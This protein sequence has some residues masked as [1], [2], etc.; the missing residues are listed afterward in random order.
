MKVIY[1]NGTVGECNPE[2]ELHIIRHSAAHIMAQA[3]K[4]LYPNAKFAYGPANEKGFYY[5]VDLGDIK[6]SDEDL[7][8]IEAEM[9]K[10]VK[11]NLPIKP[12]ILPREEAIKFMEE[13]GETYKVEHI[14]DLAEDAP[15]SFFTQ[16][17]YVDMC[18]GPHLC[19]TK[20]LKAFKI[21]SQSGAYWKNN[22][23]NTMLTR[24]NGTAFATKEELEAHL[25]ALE[26]A[27]K[28]DHNKIG[29]ELEFF[30]TVDEIGQGLPILLPKGSRVVQL[31]Q[32][33]VEDVEQKNGYLLTKTPLMAKRDLYRI[34]GHWDHYLDG[35]FILVD[36][37]DEEN[38]CL[39]L[40]PMTCPFQ[41]QVFLNKGRSYR[42]LPMRLGETS[43]LFRNEDSC[44]MH[45][46]IRVRQFTISEGHLVLRPDQLEKEFEGCLN[47]CKYFLGT[48]GL[49]DNCTFRFS[50]WDPNN[51]KKYEGTPQQWNEAQS[52]MEK[53]LNN[54]DVKYEIGID[55]AAFYGPKLDIQYKNVYGKEDTIVTIQ[56]D[57]L[58]AEKFG[59][60]YTDADG[61]K[62]LPYII[63]RTSLGCYERTL[64]YLLETYAGALPAW[65]SPEQVR[66][67]TITDRAIDKANEVYE[68]LTANGYR[69]TID[70]SANT[71]KYKVRNAQL[72][73]VPYM[74]IIGDKD[75]ENNT[76]SVRCR[77]GED[78]GT[79]TFENFAEILKDVVDN[80]KK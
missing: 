14:A 30:T 51:T 24:I 12:S 43:T 69:V 80:K 62:K 76:I 58:L 46:L 74:I 25:V 26:E 2:E 1:A 45:G 34:S 59:M 39:A 37:H 55:E 70:D 64:A 15:I 3:I 7:E 20:A 38:E 52:V 44:E 41:Y 54:L 68:K 13:R 79:T 32:R 49:L 5:D 29:R 18:T 48:V 11:E 27:K 72:E 33:W 60:Y 19:Y 10:I 73:K 22:K 57:M 36:P 17:D 50:Q 75:I 8:K 21:L 35:M 6:L 53:I 40:R 78:I 63:H 16:G 9:K 67:L 23:D 31:L 71:L 77:G 4:R 28:R 66:I 42:D 61:Q 65:L 47:L 56:I